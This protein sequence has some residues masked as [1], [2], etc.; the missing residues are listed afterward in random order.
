MDLWTTFTGLSRNIP[1]SFHRNAQ[2]SK[3]KSTLWSSIR[4]KTIRGT[5]I[6]EF[7]TEKHHLYTFNGTYQNCS[8]YFLSLEYV[9]KNIC[10]WLIYNFYCL[11]CDNNKTKQFGEPSWHETKFI[12]SSETTVF[13]VFKL[14]VGV[15]YFVILPFSTVL[16]SLHRWINSELV[17][18]G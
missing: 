5:K 8:I 9:S 10:F 14:N 2:F 13:K 7:H 11:C 17:L 18:N 3:K 1:E 15:M 12:S 16:R 4:L 6:F